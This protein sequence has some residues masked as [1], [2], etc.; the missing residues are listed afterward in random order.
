MG[1]S[2]LTEIAI[3]VGAFSLISNTALQ[4]KAHNEDFQKHNFGR[5]HLAFC[6]F[7]ANSPAQEGVYFPRTKNDI[8]K[9]LDQFYLL[10]GSRC[11]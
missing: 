8:K 10:G 6:I 1:G 3:I 9:F 7:S 5:L 4:L 11:F 2:S